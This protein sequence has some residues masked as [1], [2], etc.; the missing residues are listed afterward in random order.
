[1]TV[2]YADISWKSDCNKALTLRAT[3]CSPRHGRETSCDKLRLQEMNSAGILW[4]AQTL[5][6]SAA[7]SNQT[8]QLMVTNSQLSTHGFCDWVHGMIHFAALLTQ[9]F[10]F[11]VMVNVNVIYPDALLL[12]IWI[13]SQPKPRHPVHASSGPY[14]KGRQ[15]GHSMIHA[16]CTKYQLSW[17]LQEGPMENC[18]EC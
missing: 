10:T 18:L 2:I 3:V 1:M 9:T 14:T 17:Y 5:S 7:H 12:L 15:M 8:C 11:T 4:H 13:Q 6:S 16:C